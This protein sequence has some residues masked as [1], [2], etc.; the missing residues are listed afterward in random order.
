MIIEKLKS[1]DL[2][3][4]EEIQCLIQHWKPYSGSANFREGI[5][6]SVEFFKNNKDVKSIISDTTVLG[7]SLKK[8]SDWIA[9]EINPILIGNGLSKIAFV[10]PKSAF[11]NLAVENFKDQSQAVLQ[12]Q[13]AESVESAKEWIIS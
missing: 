6:K 2:E 5:N 3:Y 10:V 13:Y 11:A 8:D 1:C 7:P 9:Q 12:V 4:L